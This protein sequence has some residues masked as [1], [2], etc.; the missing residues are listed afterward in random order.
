MKKNKRV[1]P[2]VLDEY[3]ANVKAANGP[4][5]MASA[6]TLAYSRLNSL[7]GRNFGTDYRDEIEEELKN[8]RIKN[9]KE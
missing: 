1:P 3:A 6:K 7:F 8:V 5:K 4:A 2:A 9:G